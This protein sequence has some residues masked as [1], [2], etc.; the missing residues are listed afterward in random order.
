MSTQL[1][2]FGI[3][4]ALG[5]PLVFAGVVL[6]E[7]AVIALVLLPWRAAQQT[8]GSRVS[9][10]VFELPAHDGEAAR[11]LTPADWER[12]ERNAAEIFSALGLDLDTPGTRDTP[13]RLVRALSTPPTATTATRS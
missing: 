1:A 12:L 2:A 10:N 4:I 9:T 7:V 3:L 8:G 5:Y 13:R 6:A 11:D